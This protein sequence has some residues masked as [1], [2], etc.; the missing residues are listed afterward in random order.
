MDRFHKFVE[1]A[2]YNQ[3]KKLNDSKHSLYR[4]DKPTNK[5]FPEMIEIYSRN[6]ID[7]KLSVMNQR[8]PIA[9][10]GAD[11]LS[12]LLLSDEYYSLI[13][14]ATLLSGEGLRYLSIGYLIV[15][16]A[17]AWLDLTLRKELGEKVKSSDI[18][19]HINDVF[20]LAQGLTGNELL[21]LNEI[22]VEDMKKF[23]QRMNES[24]IDYEISI[25]SA[26]SKEETVEV[27]VKLFCD[28]QILVN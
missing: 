4:F 8:R 15:F 20:Q 23:I 16:K 27:L 25:R 18:K 3:Y 13:E 7:F 14:Y 1:D 26:F 9:F 12:A 24:E 17:K 22:V 19:K 28:S 11:S 21:H 10:D 6:P 2:G 5:D